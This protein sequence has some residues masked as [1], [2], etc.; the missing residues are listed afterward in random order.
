MYDIENPVVRDELWSLPSISCQRK[1]EGYD[2]DKP[3]Q[4]Q[5]IDFIV[6]TKSLDNESS[7]RL[8]NQLEWIALRKDILEHG[9]DFEVETDLPE[10]DEW[11]LNVLKIHGYCTEV[12]YDDVVDLLNENNLNY[13]ECV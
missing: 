9:S 7:N 13:V 1:Y 8:V 2:D 5:R 6:D 4:K 3:A 11:D 10:N 12:A